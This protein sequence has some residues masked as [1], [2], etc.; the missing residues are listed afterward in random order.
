MSH[1]SRI[2]NPILLYLS[3]AAALWAYGYILSSLDDLNSLRTTASFLS[4]S[5][6]K[7]HYI[8]ARL[9]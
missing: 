6:A 7:V 1:L 4:L 9:C 3:V 8:L 2:K 5:K